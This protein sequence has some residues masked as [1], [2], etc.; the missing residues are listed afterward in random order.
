MKISYQLI[1]ALIGKKLTIQSL[2]SFIREHSDDLSASLTTALLLEDYKYLEVMNNQGDKWDNMDIAY[3][4]HIPENPFILPRE[5]MSLR[6]LAKLYFD[7]QRYFTKEDFYKLIEKESERQDMQ[8][9]SLF[10]QFD[11][12]LDDVIAKDRLFRGNVERNEP[13][14]CGS[15]KKYKHCHGNEIVNSESAPK[16]GE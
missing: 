7:L 3:F 16:S 2:D 13:C 12:N 4:S 1:A 6:G 9:D 11:M 5:P 14:P 15:G 10:L 8:P